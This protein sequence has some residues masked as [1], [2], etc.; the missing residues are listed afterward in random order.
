ML[1]VWIDRIESAL[2]SI[3]PSLS[4]DSFTRQILSRLLTYN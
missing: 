3:I 4:N 1:G 2:L